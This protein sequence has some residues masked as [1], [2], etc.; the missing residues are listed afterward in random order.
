M[1]RNTIFTNAA[2]LAATP[3]AA[4][5]GPQNGTVGSGTAAITTPTAQSTV[6]DQ[7][8]AKAIINWQGFSIGADEFVTFNQPDSSSITL[9]RVTGAD[10]SS[11]LGNLSANGQVFLVNPNGIY[12]GAG[13]TLDVGGLVAST[14]DISDADFLSGNYLFTQI[15]GSDDASV[16]ND[17][18][19]NARENGYV[20][21]ASNRTVNNGEIKAKFGQIALVAGG[22]VTLDI[23]GD[24]LI[25]FSVDAQV[26]AEMAGVENTGDLIADG[27]RIVLTSK[28]TDGLIATVVNNTGLIQAN[29]IAEQ[30]GEIFLTGD[31]SISSTGNLATGGSLNINAGTTVNLSGGVDSDDLDI[32]AGTS[33]SI[34]SNV[35]VSGDVDIVATTGD[36][37][38]DDVTA[39]TGDIDIT[40]QDGSV[41]TESLSVVV[42]NN[43]DSDATISI[44]AAT[45]VNLNGDVTAAAD[46]DNSATVSITAMGGTISQAAATTIIADATDGDDQ[47]AQVGL[48]GASV[49]LQG[50]VEAQAKGA[51][52]E[53]G[54]G[55]ATAS[56]N[57]DVSSAL[58]ALT[59]N[60]ITANVENDGNASILLTGGATTTINDV[61]TA[62]VEDDGNASINVGTSGNQVG[63]VT[64]DNATPEAASIATAVGGSGS[65]TFSLDASGDFAT[66]SLNI[67]V[68]DGISLSA[69]SV[70][71]GELTANS[72]DV[73]VTA[74][75]GVVNTTNITADDI[76]VSGETVSTGDLA[77][78]DGEAGITASTGS[79]TIGTVE[80]SDDVTIS[81]ATSLVV[82]DITVS[83]DEVDLSA[84]TTLTAAAIDNASAINFNAG[85]LVTTGTNRYTANNINLAG[86]N[87]SYD[88]L[89]DATTITAESARTEG[90]VNSLTLDDSGVA[91]LNFVDN[92]GEFGLV[93]LSFANTVMVGGDSI[94]ASGVSITNS[95]G[96]LSINADVTANV[97]DISYTAQNGDLNVNG[98]TIATSDSSTINLTA[99]GSNNDL[100]ISKAISANAINATADDNI[101][102]TGSGLLSAETVVITS[103][104]TMNA[105]IDVDTNATTIMAN[106]AENLTIN[107]TAMNAAATLNY[108][109]ATYGSFNVSFGGDGNLVGA[110][111]LT[112]TSV[113][114]SGAELTLPATINADGISIS[115]DTINAG[116]LAAVDNLNISGTVTGST[117]DLSAGEQLTTDNIMATGNVTVAG[118]SVTTGTVSSTTAGD[119]TLSSTGGDIETDSLST[120]AGAV[121]A[122]AVAG[123]ISITGNVT[124]TTGITLSGDNV[125]TQSDGNLT[126]T[127]NAINLTAN[128]GNVNVGQLSASNG[129]LNVNASSGDV[130]L[131]DAMAA[132]G[133]IAGNN[134]VLEDLNAPASVSATNLTLSGDYTRG[135]FS[136]AED[137]TL[138][139]SITANVVDLGA[140]DVLAVNG[141]IT[142]N[143]TSSSASLS[144]N[145]S[146]S[147]DGAVNTDGISVVTANGDISQ[148]AMGNLMANTIS[149]T[150]NSGDITLN[151]L[152]TTGTASTAEQI[153]TSFS[154]KLSGNGTLTTNT[155]NATGVG[156]SASIGNNANSRLAVD[157]QT[158]NLD[159][160]LTNIFLS[161]LNTGANLN[162]T[163]TTNLLDVD[164][165]GSGS[166]V[167]DSLITVQSASLSAGNDL[168]LNQAINAAVE[169]NLSAGG[170][171]SAGMNT[172]TADTVTLSGDGATYG[173][174]GNNLLTETA[175]LVAA[176]DIDALYINNTGV[177][178]FSTS[179]GTGGA[180]LINVINSDAISF[181]S[182]IS[183]ATITVNAGGD[184]NSGSDTLTANQINLTGVGGVDVDIN[185]SAAEFV[186]N[187]GINNVTI[188]NRS[189]SV[190]SAFTFNAASYNDVDIDSNA[191]TVVNASGLDVNMLDV[192]SGAG[193]LTINTNLNS[194]TTANINAG[195]DLTL[196]SLIAGDTASLSAGGQLTANA[197]TAAN[198]INLNGGGVTSASL[199]ASDG[200]VSITAGDSGVSVTN[201][202]ANA[203]AINSTG[204]TQVNGSINSMGIMINDAG[205]VVLA[206]GSALAATSAGSANI[207]ISAANI[208]QSG[209]VITTGETA[210]ID[211]DASG[212][213][214]NNGSVTANATDNMSVIKLGANSNP[215]SISGS[216]LYTADSINVNAANNADVNVTS[217]TGVLNVTGGSALTFDNT[218]FT[219]ATTFTYD[220]SNYSTFNLNFGGSAN[221][222]GGTN[223][224]DTASISARGALNLAQDYTGNLIN[225][226]ANGNVT[227]GLLDVATVN[228]SGFGNANFG[229][230]V[231]NLMTNASSLTLGAGINDVFIDNTANASNAVLNFG[232]SRYGIVDFNFGGFD[233]LGM[234]G[235]RLSST[236]SVN[237]N[238]I[239]AD[240]LAISATGDL[241]VNAG[242]D[243]GGETVPGV[244]GDSLLTAAIAATA[245]FI[246][247]GGSADP[248]ASFIASNN[249]S[250]NINGLSQAGRYLLLRGDNI[251]IVGTTAAQ[252]LLVQFT[253]FTTTKIVN[254]LTVGTT[255]GFEQNTV[256]AGDFNLTFDE[257]FAPFLGTTI[258]LGEQGTTGDII[259]G[260]NGPVNAGSK[261][262]LFLTDA[263]VAGFDNIAGTGLLGRADETGGFF[264]VRPVSRF[265]STSDLAVF[266]FKFGARAASVEINAGFEGG[267]DSGLGDSNSLVDFDDENIDQTTKQ[268]S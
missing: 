168:T 102:T 172:L 3:I 178:D 76:L 80:A 180:N 81:A 94:T 27:G 121:S 42:P 18:V 183:A 112:A 63:A 247:D 209:S 104:S 17:G 49:D 255:I 71:V 170:N 202:N 107:N 115:A 15:D 201:V 90:N 37:D 220:R 240:A 259:I 219:Q 74:T 55:T 239:T 244:Q 44:S 157:A 174:A 58:G 176:N 235:P 193:S 117:L 177:L 154:G 125:T 162:T 175:N 160:T 256:G 54:D 150:A 231:N 11:I 145:S 179:A 73:T 65:A 24:G 50:S 233:S 126:T 32:T 130:S 79:A 260:R 169:I 33:I 261:N 153:T 265:I 266:G 164:F 122:A 99:T 34:T 267:T 262:L 166:V 148:G 141:T 86:D 187:G 217:N 221:V 8:S 19:I 214:I 238:T 59:S 186:L 132:S 165:I 35:S 173:S 41:T 215:S 257:H 75:M 268:C 242:F 143:G 243:V 68:A 253:P 134:V 258:A 167:G 204:G 108:S 98:E 159:G 222:I 263:T 9:N 64:I 106:G 136:A 83:D 188:D 95:M 25:N 16:V 237:G 69:A 163:A 87:A 128:N 252:Q 208:R 194:D 195:G 31:D 113:S 88:I 89:T 223:S 28:A 100:T 129:T 48:N 226:V 111:S 6:I 101:T 66:N 246:T 198:G 93:D 109:Q 67:N 196:A 211:F 250:V 20:V 203:V 158:I 47:T 200:D 30:N 36:V 26:A 82:S 7:T 14:F 116:T 103:M 210:Q 127:N 199:S 2:L 39:N 144:G 216:G 53:S 13:A 60:T 135:D 207:S 78:A 206:D 155:F 120:L 119:V 21:L 184:I 77:A 248:N 105:D 110:A 46:G 61:L 161:A 185:T 91:T 29:G 224:S 264:V 5:A 234:P 1:K 139:G 40:A 84:G 197:V 85:G 70:E 230:A 181:S 236:S 124:A 241:V 4:F 213:I 218:A 152:T 97:A 62:S 225:I 138:I 51:P 56:I 57:I 147:L 96:D 45:D 156:S 142:G 118:E 192:N 245:P 146:V 251:D 171:V 254:G 131:G 123:D 205:D 133:S 22:G 151:G 23:V 149:L 43:G 38:V 212:S 12:F 191:D 228:L 10:P 227:S 232:G 182:D 189:G 114:L 52:G 229:S 137:L 92:D 249:L 140:G 72:G 190:A